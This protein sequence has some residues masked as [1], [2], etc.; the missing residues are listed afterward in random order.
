MTVVAATNCHHLPS[1]SSVC[2]SDNMVP[3]LTMSIGTP[4]PR[5][6]RITSALMKPTT[7]RLSC[8]STT[9]LMLGRICVNMREACEAPIASAAR[10]YSRERCFMYSART[11][12]S[13]SYTHLRAHETRHDLVCRL[14]LEK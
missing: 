12:R 11:R 13:V 6:D 8:T 3:Q 2:A 10:T 9:W 1:T 4:K 14:L 7:C 5:Y